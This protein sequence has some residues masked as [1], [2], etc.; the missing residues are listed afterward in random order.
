MSDFFV[1]GYAQE[2]IS[3]FFI[4]RKNTRT[5]D[6]APFFCFVFLSKVSEFVYPPACLVELFIFPSGARR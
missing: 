6:V 3:V 2:A 1:V 4:S 5:W